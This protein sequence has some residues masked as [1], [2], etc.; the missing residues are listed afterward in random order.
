MK[1]ALLLILLLLSF[2]AGAA[3]LTLENFNVNGRTLTPK[4]LPSGTFD[5]D[6]ANWS[7]DPQNAIQIDPSI[8]DTGLSILKAEKPIFATQLHFLQTMQPGEGIANYRLAVAQAHRSLELPPP[9]PILFSYEIIYADGKKLTTPVRWGES[10]ESWY[11]LH[12]VAPLL[13]AQNPLVKDLDTNSGEK[14]VAYPMTWP[15]PRPDTAISEIRVLPPR[16]RWVDYGTVLILGASATSEAPAGKIYYV[17][18]TPTGDDSQPGSF[19]QPWATLPYAFKQLKPGDTLYLRGGYYALNRAAV[20]EDYGDAN[21][22]WITISA[23][24]GETPVIDGFG[25]L[26]DNRLAP[27]NLESKWGPSYQRDFGVIA[28]WNASGYVRIQGLQVQNSQRSAISAH[29]VRFWSDRPGKTRPQHLAINFNT[30]YCCNH[31]GINVKFWDD[32]DVIG[33]RVARPHSE[34]MAF[35]VPGDERPGMD[36]PFGQPLSI[37]EHSQEAIDLTLN[38]R[39]VVA[40]NEVYGGG[41]EAI[42]C[43]TVQDGEIYGNYIQDCLNGIYI[44]SWSDAVARLKIYRNFIQSAF[45]AIPC[46]TEGGGDLLDFEIYENICIDSHSGGI[47]IGEATY[48]ATPATIRNHKIFN[49]TVYKGGR[50]ADSIDWLASGISISG[51]PANPNV[52]DVTVFNNIVDDALHVPFMSNFDNLDERNIVFKHNLAWPNEVRLSER[53]KESERK[54]LASFVEEKKR[55]AKDPRFMDPARGDFRLQSNSPARRAGVGGKDLG[56][57]PYG[58]AWMPGFDWAGHVTASYQNQLSWQPVFIPNELFN[59]Y[60]NNLKRPRFFQDGRYGS[61]FQPLPAGLQAI[62]GVIWHIEQDDL[63]SVITLAGAHTEAQDGNVTGIPV[64]RKANKIAFLHTCWFNNTTRKTIN[65]GEPVELA[66]YVIHYTNGTQVQIPILAGQNIGYWNNSGENLP[67]AQLAYALPVISR[68]NFA[69][70]SA[71]YNFEWTNPSP[72]KEIAS[73]DLIRVGD[74]Q[75]GTPALF[76]ISTGL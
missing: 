72:E 49:N 70:F 71:L 73:I 39:F 6:G 48:K 41:K 7:I 28:V 23:Y 42:D 17:T 3:P 21:G 74:P 66:A 52:T 64:N 16:D 55:I 20:L 51:F 32:V 36:F 62:D 1:N 4:D 56:A 47:G 5:H 27:F 31:M 40:Y 33:N 54:A 46:S 29:G 76:A 14:A 50:H 75:Q 38:T 35:S 18:P 25:V 13:W 53:M 61:D 24:P 10:I 34:R 30:I 68:G 22:Q 11:Q 9:P 26:Y 60:R 8:P 37:R 44:D 19:E 65:R 59:T 15:N 57:L 58:S 67:D 2:T 45:T 43:I 12:M 69:G 63:P